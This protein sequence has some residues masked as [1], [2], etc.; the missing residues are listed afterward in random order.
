M[1]EVTFEIKE[2]IGVINENEQSGWKKML[3][4]VS[5]N[6]GQ[7]KV[8]IREWSPDFRKMSRGITLTEQEAQQ[9]VDLLRDYKHR[10]R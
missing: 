2:K 10:K 3:C 9:V 7:P 1:S 8:D 5:W 6:G 4:I